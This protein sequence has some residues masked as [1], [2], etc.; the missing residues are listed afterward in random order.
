[1]SFLVAEAIVVA[2]SEALV[3]QTQWENKGM[4]SDKPEV[5]AVDVEEKEE[6]ELVVFR[7]QRESPLSA[8]IVVRRAR[9]NPDRDVETG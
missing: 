8:L 9:G 5:E 4:D 6:I 1:M 3:F 7:A 2:N